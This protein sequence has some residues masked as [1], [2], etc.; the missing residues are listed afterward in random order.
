MPDIPGVF[1]YRHTVHADEIDELRH[2]NNLQ[3]LAW[4][5]S[6]A[7]AHSAALG[8][9]TS[10]YLEQQSGWVVRTHEIEYFLPAFEGEEIVIQTWVA[11]MKK[12]SSLRRFIIRRAADGVRLAIAATNFAYIDFGTGR[13]CW[14]PKDVAA[15]YPMV[16]TDQ[17]PK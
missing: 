2:V 12:V 8:W 6:A 13:L 17:Q 4:T 5:Q 11:D 16:P 10:R 1:E 14:V 7:T 15:A 3:Y 9:P